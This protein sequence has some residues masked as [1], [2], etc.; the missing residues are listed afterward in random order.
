M[1]EGKTGII[2]TLDKICEWNCDFCCVDAYGVKKSR[3][4]VSI[5]SNNFN[6]QEPV[7]GD[8]KDI[9]QQG[10][11]ILVRHGLS[12]SLEDKL[13]ILE[14][15]KGS[16]IEIGFSGGDFLL[17]RENLE[18]VK[19]ASKMF[20][21]ENIGI[22]AT[23]VGM[24]VGHVEDYLEHV[25]QLDFTFD[26]TNDVDENHQ[27]SGYNDSNLNSF[28]KIVKACHSEKV[29]TQALV[30][31]SNTNK[32]PDTISDL[33]STLKQVDVD[34]VYLMRTFPVGR[35]FNSQ[36][37]PLNPDDY[38][39]VIKKYYELEKEISG[40]KVNI[41]C[42]LKYLFPEKWDDPCTFLRSTIDI[43]STGD[44][45]ADAFAYGLKGEPLLQELVFGN[46]KENHFSD[47]ITRSQIQSLAKRIQE[48]KGHCK[49]IAYTNNKSAGI[50]GF[51]SKTDPLYNKK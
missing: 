48:N 42:A 41:M 21:K 47:L 18:V 37:E 17:N 44:L 19:N 13:K 35:G 11:D 4:S 51:F 43:T 50:D 38:R 25:G 33:Y 46:L 49:V 30:P 32:N 39:S 26:N 40:P 29:I 7:S 10:Q 9:Y 27:Q 28:K 23:G 12:L 6:Y 5:T 20:G 45:I 24:R 31:I 36:L 8:T 16:N 34:K 3:D 22:T 1:F 2:W 15:L 14:N